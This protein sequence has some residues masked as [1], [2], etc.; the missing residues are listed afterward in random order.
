VIELRGEPR[1]V[2]DAEAADYVVVPADVD[3]RV[4]RTLVHAQRATGADVVTCGL[5][6]AD[7]RL[8]FFAGDAGGLGALANTFGTVALVR[9]ALVD[10]AP[11]AWPEQR[12]TAWPWLACL[13]ASGAS[14]VSV[15]LPLAETRDAPGTVE[16]DPAAALQAV[17]QLERVLPDSVRGAARL[18]AGLVA[19]RHRESVG[20][21]GI[22]RRARR[23]LRGLLGDVR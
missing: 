7:G 17:Q 18:A 15:P 10:A 4:R 23:A 14:I 16:N 3:E 2:A 19:D 9:R 22:S 8:H 11:T 21:G 6:L 13:A 20:D 12:D 5:R 1:P